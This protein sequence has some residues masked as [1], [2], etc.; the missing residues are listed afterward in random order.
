MNFK[1]IFI[2]Q[3]ILM[4]I[5]II[6]LFTFTILLSLTSCSPPGEESI[7]FLVD[8][9]PICEPNSITTLECSNQISNAQ[10]ASQTKACNSQGSDYTYGLCGVET[11]N[12]GYKIVGNE[13]LA[14]SFEVREDDWQSNTQISSTSSDIYYKAIASS[15]SNV[16]VA[17]GNGEVF[18]KRSFDEGDTWT[19]E[20][21]IADGYLYL[22]DPLIADDNYVYVIYVKDLTSR[23]DLIA[24]RPTGNIYFKR[25][26]D[27]GNTWSTE[28]QLTSA[29]GAF[30]MSIGV[31]GSNIHVTWMDYRSNS[32]WDIYYTRSQNRGATWETEVN[33]VPGSE[34][35]GG[36]RPSIATYGQNI[37]ITWMDGRNNRSPCYI[38]DRKQLPKCTDI[39]L[40]ISRNNGNSWESDLQITNSSEYAGRPEISSSPDGSL[41]AVSYDGTVSN[42]DRVEQFVMKSTDEGVSWTTPVQVSDGGVG[43]STH[44]TLLV[45]N[46]TI[47][48]IWFDT[49][50]NTNS[51]I[52]YVIAQHAGNF[53]NEYR[54][55]NNSASSYTPL[56]SVSDN[57]LQALWA[58]SRSGSLQLYYSKKPLGN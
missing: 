53:T 29:Q 3:N 55:T 18:M 11:C 42:G 10:T 48:L 16:Y 57:Y 40:K 45:T 35:F 15:G 30:R 4:T 14:D 41:V 58:D 12:S 27:N 33:L 36:H 32:T 37:Y 6:Y 1:K 13:C 28:T 46:S 7:Q 43:D 25:S 52:Y 39:Y 17:R 2:D 51:E 56:L 54:L 26:D 5:K 21:K 22:S 44:G 24:P 34:A 23:T 31:S 20:Q 9:I 47:N 8:D 49:R 19:S 38:E 50:Y